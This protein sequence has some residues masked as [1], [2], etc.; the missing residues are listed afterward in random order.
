MPEMRGYS[1]TDFTD[2]KNT[3]GIEGQFYANNSTM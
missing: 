3:E 2:T 1:H